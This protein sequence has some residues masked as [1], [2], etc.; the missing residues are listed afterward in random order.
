[1]KRCFVVLL[2][3]L[4]LANT[5]IAKAGPWAPERGHGYA[6]V[7]LKYLYGFGFVGSDGERR[8]YPAYHEL[9]V[10]SY[11]N[12]G[13]GAGFSFWWHTDLVRTF[14]LRN[15]VE[16]T[17]EHHASPGDPAVGVTYQFLQAG[18]LAMSAG[19]GLR[20]PLAS[21]VPRQVVYSA[22]PN[23]AGE[24]TPLGELRVG[25][26]AFGVPMVLEAGYGFDRW[27][28]AASVGYEVRAN[29]YRDRLTWSA[30]VGG[31]F[32]DD[33]SGRVR[34]SGAHSLSE[35]TGDAPRAETPSGLGNGVSWA[36]FAVEGEYQFIEDSYV[37]IAFEGGLGFL[38]SQTGGPVVNLFVATNF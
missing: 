19:A 27:Y 21:D 13:L 11:G 33:F 4:L 5:S 8:D 28:L 30:E 1:M 25:E 37:G 23:E 36:G 38:R 35:G 14:H 24:Y 18:R 29:G 10:A 6:K 2:G 26:G 9:F 15:P 31:R 3:G 20:V 22:S 17:W 12:V 16:N 7:W 34:L 32:G